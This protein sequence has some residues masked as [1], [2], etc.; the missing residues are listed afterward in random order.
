MRLQQ[1]QKMAKGMG[2]NPYRT[3]KT[4]LIRMIQREENNIDCYGTD[5][6]GYCQEEGCSWRSDCFSLNNSHPEG[7]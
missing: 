4:D 2:V 1:I 6:V 7:R 5:R 3:K